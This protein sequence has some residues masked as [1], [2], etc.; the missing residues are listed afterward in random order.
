MTSPDCA[1]SI[2]CA[3]SSGRPSTVNRSEY[4]HWCRS[5]PGRD[6]PGARAC[7][8]DFLVYQP[9]WC[10]ARIWS[11]KDALRAPCPLTHARLDVRRS[12]Q[13]VERGRDVPVPPPPLVNETKERRARRGR[14]PALDV[15]RKS[16]ISRRLFE[17]EQGD[18]IG[19]V[20]ELDVY[21][22]AA[23]R[24]LDGFPDVRVLVRSGVVLESTRRCRDRGFDFIDRRST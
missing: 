14:S 2:S 18:V 17:L 4:T 15:E 10:Y 1:R 3:S 22:P 20:G 6:Q 24:R 12:V 21:L 13:S 9:E 11:G 23:R 16:A 5:V 7:V 8:A 19:T